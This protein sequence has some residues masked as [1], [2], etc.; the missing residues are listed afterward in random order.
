MSNLQSKFTSF[1]D[2]RIFCFIVVTIILA[3]ISI[4]NT[5]IKQINIQILT[6]KDYSKP[7]P[8]PDW[9]SIAVKSFHKVLVETDNNRL[10][11][12]SF[13]QSNQS[14]SPLSVDTAYS[15]RWIVITSINYP[16]K[17]INK[18]S[19]LKDWALVLVADIST[20]KDWSHPNCVFLSIES[21]RRLLLEI[22]D[23]IPYRHYGRKIIGYLYAIRHGA[24]IIYETDDDNELISG[25]EEQVLT[26]Q[27]IS[28]SNKAYF[29]PATPQ[30]MNTFDSK[31]FLG[32]AIFGTS[33]SANTT[34]NLTMEGQITVNP[35]HYFGQ[36][37]I[38]PR[39]YPLRL[40]GDNISISISLST[41]RPLIQQGLANGDPDLDAI[42]RLTQSDR[43]KRID[44][45]FQE[46]PPVA[47][48][49]GLLVPFNS[50]NTLFHY[51]AFWAL[52]LPVTTTFRVCDIWRGYF[53]QRLLWELTPQ[54]T[55]TFHSPSVLQ[56]RNPHNYIRDFEEESQLYTQTE[57]LIIF[58]RNWTCSRGGSHL[59]GVRDCNLFFNKIYFLAVDMVEA[60]FW[61][62]KDAW[63]C[64]N[65][66]ID[67]IKHGYRYDL[68]YQIPII[69]PKATNQQN[70][71]ISQQNYTVSS[72]NIPST[73]VAVCVS[74]QVRTLNMVISS[75]LPVMTV[76][77][78]VYR[79]KVAWRKFRSGK[80]T[81]AMNIQ[82]LLFDQLPAFD[83]F[84]FVSTKEKHHREPHVNDT[85]I[86]ESLRP[87]SSS[88][89]LFCSVVKEMDITNPS[90]NVTALNSYT[91]AQS[92]ELRQGLLQQLNGLQQCNAMRKEYS[93]KS[94]TQY[95]HWIRLRPDSIFFEPFPNI[96]SIRFV[97]ET[98]KQPRI[99]YATKKKCCC[100]NEDWF[101]VGTIETMDAY[102]DRI[103][104]L[105]TYKNRNIW[106][107]EVFAI[108]VLTE[109]LK[110]QLLDNDPRIQVCIYKPKDRRYTGEP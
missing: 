1:Y 60:N 27:E 8:L 65:F 24:K 99:V 44:I 71:S 57:Q 98:T 43:H 13:T 93:R 11:N 87:R 21:Q 31:P 81:T 64:V 14:L 85:R 63:L 55:L 78:A 20:P 5:L 40:V 37:N 73:R 7:P 4:C 92:Q 69:K 91:Y 97:D 107:A 103:N 95:T 50:Q 39:G 3:A 48:S 51:D 90:T 94:G 30:E 83:V 38:W 72:K 16:T 9:S 89:R 101:G 79:P 33:T 47:V 54:A 34:N 6:T 77:R 100:G 35:Y 74:G 86:C 104:L 106:S 19:K 61:K 88:N 68:K 15:L 58:L 10:F 18:L 25:I 66:L 28:T 22:H 70:N 2:K 52:W 29:L 110:A 49:H 80:H 67:L 12:T 76:D 42:F 105:H 23:T 46:K 108:D 41:V 102:F 59:S 109:T 82:S 17:T 56:L 32:R 75:T 96:T 53:V 62:M 26:F 84:M 36:P 45:Q